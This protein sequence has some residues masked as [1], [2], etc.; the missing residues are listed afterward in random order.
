MKNKKKKS[1]INCAYYFDPQGSFHGPQIYICV[2]SAALQ[3]CRSLSNEPPSLISHEW[4]KIFTYIVSN[5]S[6]T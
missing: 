2:L 6:D 3:I 1:D 5:K 4:F